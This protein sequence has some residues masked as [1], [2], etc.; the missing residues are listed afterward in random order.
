MADK[1]KNKKSKDV[2]ATDINF[3]FRFNELK[4]FKERFNHCNVPQRYRE[5]PTLANWVCRQRRNYKIK[6]PK[7]FFLARIE[8]LNSIGF[9]W[10]VNKGPDW[11]AIVDELI[12]F[13]QQFG[14]CDVP[15][16]FKE[17][18]LLGICVNQLRWYYKNKDYRKLP[19]KQIERLNSIGF[20][21]AVMKRT[22]W[23]ERFRE[24]KEFKEKYGRFNRF[25]DKEDDFRYWVAEQRGKNKRG[26]L[27]KEHYRLLSSIGFF[28]LPNAELKHALKK[29]KNVLRFGGLEGI[30]EISIKG[31][32]SEF[33]IN[34]RILG[35]K[36]SWEPMLKKFLLKFLNDISR[37]DAMNC[38]IKYEKVL[39]IREIERQVNCPINTM[40][41]T[42]RG[43]KPFPVKWEI[44]LKTFLDNMANDL[45][46][47]LR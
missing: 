27:P 45:N 20:H 41:K 7:K 15:Q 40:Q 5:N 35:N 47:I 19:K 8:K 14:H 26:K 13:K 33:I 37:L 38:I 16:K 23:E 3:E 36:R 29:Y 39:K 21:W 12:K 2:S 11:D 22:P 31:T 28:D 6:G 4:Q 9:N 32:L 34:R 25:T 46:L 44:P 18:H 1:N 42:I 43:T 30:L 17:N 24:L 10:V